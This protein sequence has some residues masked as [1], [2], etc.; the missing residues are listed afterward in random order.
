[1]GA[2][3][4]FRF[5]LPL[6][7]VTLGSAASLAVTLDQCSS[8]VRGWET[9]TEAGTQ[10]P[11]REP[12]AG[13]NV[14]LSQ[15]DTAAMNAHLEIMA[16]LGITWVRQTFPWSAIEPEPGRFQWDQWDRIVEAVAAHEGLQL[17]AV[18]NLPPQWARDPQAANQ[19]TAPPAEVGDFARFARLFA[20]RYGSRIHYYQVW[21]EPNLTAAWGNL[22]PKPADYV[23]LLQAAYTAIHEADAEATVIAAGLAPTTEPGPRNISDIL[24]LRAMY[25][26]GGQNAFDAVAGKPYGFDTGPDDRRVSAQVLNF[27]RLILLREEMVR[28]GDGEKALWGSHFGW[29]ALPDDWDGAPSPWGAVSYEEQIGYIQ[30]AFERAAREWPWTGGLIL[31]HWQPA[32]APDDP[33]WGFAVIPYGSENEPGVPDLFGGTIAAESGA[34]PGRYHSRTDNASYSGEW[35]FSELGA[36][37]GQQADSEATFTFVGTAVALE[38]RRADYRAYLFLTIDG[39]PAPALPTDLDGQSYI[40]LT[41]DDLEPHTDTIL[42][43][44]GLPYGEHTMHLRAERGWDQWALAAYRV[45]VPPDTASYDAVA[46]FSL[47]VLVIGGSMVLVVVSRYP[48]GT[49][50]AWCSLLWRRLGQTGQVIMAGL[51][52]W[53]LMLNMLLTWQEQMPALVR[54]DP[55]GL[56]MGLVTAGVLYFSPSFVLTIISAGLLWWLIYQRLELGLLLT[57]FW[58]P[59]FLFPVELFRYALPMA[60]VCVLLTA[61]AWSVH[62]FVRWLSSRRQSLSIAL[63]WS[64]FVKR[65]NAL[66]WGMFLF[67]VFGTLA[68][69]WSVY[70][71]EA[72]REWRIMIFEPSLFY[73]MLRTTVSGRAAV[74]RLVGVFVLAGVVIA[75]LGLGMYM[76]GEGAITAEGG[77]SRLAGVYGSPNNLGLFLDRVL[78]FLVVF[79]LLTTRNLVRIAFGILILV[80]LAAVALSQS[81]G[82]ILLGIP[83]GIGS[84]LLLWHWRRGILIIAASTVA[85]IIAAIPLSQHP[86]F[87]RLLDFSSGTS[88]FR[89]R[90]WQSAL[91]MIA[92]NPVRGLGLDQFLYAYR[93]RYILPD[94]WQEPNLSHPHNILL[95]FWT[96]LGI[97]GVIAIGWLQIAF[98]RSAW[99]VYRTAS[100][101]MLRA[102]SIG[103]MGSMAALLA[104]GLVDNSV[105]VPDLAYVFALLVALPSLLHTVQV[106]DIP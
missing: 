81:V 73:V 106:D 24:Y 21:D 14:E 63:P 67:F 54:R 25:E 48:P 43:A 85:G 1:M 99:Q 3:N 94:A 101:N 39:R 32:A 36:D 61:L 60:E 26:N 70:R 62:M 41:A 97:G 103:M 66:D 38:L 58:A 19:P 40:I 9:A 80:L 89:L 34:T 53:V 33:V 45:G 13:V 96:R 10:L 29:N 72:L 100:D 6:L 30:A 82:A 28:R 93:G 83:V 65:L 20:E 79:W 18:L 91:H 104:H 11:F 27:S 4:R 88:F 17:V 2:M 42:V 23:A 98:W 15:Y 46:L 16:S 51:T 49:F 77:V 22:D 68:V 64:G 44:A 35:E 37:F 95:D 31:Q 56:L 92:D 52:S 59:F 86:R 71:A 57:I 87:S 12:L 105:F 74:G 47:M 55:P 75:V 7:I 5:F 76:V 90:L 78:P 102:V 84:V 8:Y 69:A 50:G